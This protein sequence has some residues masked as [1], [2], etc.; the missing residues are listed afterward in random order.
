VVDD[1]KDSAESLSTLL[2]LMG[3]DVRSAQDGLEAVEAAAAFRPDLVLLD[4]GMPKLN[5]YEACRRIRE[6]PFGSDMV[7]VAVTGWGQ[8]DD[9]R[10]AKE[11]GFDLHMV[12]PVEPQ[13]IEKLLRSL[14]ARRRGL[15]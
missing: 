7:L 6:L 4:I 13:A 3:N 2:R 1:L 14:P 10:K 5:G 9:R 15:A 11:A 12:K 8:E